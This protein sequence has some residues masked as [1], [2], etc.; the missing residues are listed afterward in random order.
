MAPPAVS[1]PLKKERAV[2][3]VAF[4]HSVGLRSVSVS[5]RGSGR[6]MYMEGFLPLYMGCV[7]VKNLQPVESL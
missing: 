1:G 2:R 3:A 5:I 7:K 4:V 6:E